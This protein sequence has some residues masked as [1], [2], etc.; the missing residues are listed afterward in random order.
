MQYPRQIPDQPGGH[1]IDIADWAQSDDFSIHPVGSKPKRMVFAPAAPVDPFIVPSH[2]YLFKTAN[3]FRAQQ[4]W[5]EVIAY[6]LAKVLNLPVPPCFIAIDSRTGET[7]ALVE[8]F[9]GYPNEDQA[10]RLVHGVDAI[11]SLYGGRDEPQNVLTN[12]K[13]TRVF[14]GS[15]FGMAWWG[16]VYAFDAIIANN[17]R[18]TENWGFLV[19]RSEAGT[20][21]YSIAPMYDNGSSL[22][23]QLDDGK[24]R[25]TRGE[26]L[27]RFNAKGRHQSGWD[28]QTPATL[29][30]F[31]L[32]RRLAASYPDA[33]PTMRNCLA[34]SDV[35]VAG[36][37]DG[38]T[39]CDVPL[40]FGPDR[41]A[42]VEALLLSRRELLFSALDPI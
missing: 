33:R 28:R 3:G 1:V 21:S 23:F 2:A 18:H 42:F 40:G 27:D 7:G 29:P 4:V 15:T 22:G 20:T 38:C 39:K 17:D 19:R 30:H 31:E 36:I 8:F 25:S 11:S 35:A 34:F 32:C 37:L 26:S 13:T 14:L 41:A 6:R 16:Q 10:A 24:L 9:F 12:A 5:S